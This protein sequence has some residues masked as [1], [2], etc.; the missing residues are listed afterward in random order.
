MYRISNAKGSY[1]AVQKLVSANLAHSI[2]L[3]LGEPDENGNLTDTKR[4]AEYM[5]EVR[6]LKDLIGKKATLGNGL[7]EKKFP[8]EEVILSRYS[9]ILAKLEDTRHEFTFD[10]FGEGLIFALVEMRKNGVPDYL[11][12]YGIDPY[13]PEEHELVEFFEEGEDLYNQLKKSVEEMAPDFFAE[14]FDK[15]E[16]T[17]IT[18]YCER[19]KI[20][21]IKLYATYAEMYSRCILNESCYLDDEMDEEEMNIALFTNE[22]NEEDGEFIKDKVRY[23]FLSPICWDQDYEF[24]MESLSNADSLDVNLKTG[25]TIVGFTLQNYNDLFTG[26]DEV[27]DIR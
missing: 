14:V 8:W 13:T 12:K 16:H 7:L 5:K 27:R 3:Y 25:L 18:E 6:Y 23:L 4:A 26:K 9:D 19:K 24:V 21:T 15:G 2:K 20:D 10:E 1:E 22:I 17:E 11:N